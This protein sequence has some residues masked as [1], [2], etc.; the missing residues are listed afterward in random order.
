MR[1]VRLGLVI[2][3]LF[4]LCASAAIS[5]APHTYSNDRCGGSPANWSSQGR[6]FGE[7]LVHDQL[8]VSPRGVTWNDVPVTRISLKRRLSKARQ[9]PPSVSLEVVFERGSDCHLVRSIRKQVDAVVGCGH[10]HQCI[11]Y[12]DEERRRFFPPSKP[13]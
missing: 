11:E 6:E 8:Y 3:G 2:P 13:R 10:G 1:I 7:L 4:A 9:T 12:S 5:A